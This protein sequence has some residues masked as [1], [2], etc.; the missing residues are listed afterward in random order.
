M[1]TIRNGG[2]RVEEP[3]L[4]TRIIRRKGSL[5][6]PDYDALV[7]R[8]TNIFAVLEREGMR[9]VIPAANLITDAG[10]EHYAEKGAGEAATNAFGALV[11]GTA[12]DTGH[13]AKTSTFANITEIAASEKG[14]DTGYPQT[15]DSDADNGGT[16]GVDVVTFRTSYTKGDFSATGISSGCVTNSVPGT[17]EPLL[18]LYDFASAFDKTSDDTLK[19]F[20]NH[21]MNGV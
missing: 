16:T 6:F 18:T 5:Y 19:V 9:R 8:R 21:E 4:V 20:T 7:D 12:T 15:N 17:S 1:L 10:D 3:G 11:L 13:P 14:H 2:E